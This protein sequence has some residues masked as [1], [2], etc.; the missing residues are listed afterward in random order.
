MLA[1]LVMGGVLPEQWDA[2][3]R[4]VDFFD[5]K[6]DLEALLA[7][8]GLEEGFRFVAD[9]HSALH[10]GQCARIQRDGASVGWLGM[11]H[12]ELEGRLELPA[13]TY[14]FELRL[15]GIA[16]GILPVFRPLSKFPSIR[17]DLA[18]VV[19]E[20]VSFGQ[21]RDCIRSGA[22]EILQDILLFDVYTGDKIDSGR[23]SLAL[24]LILQD[25]SHTLTDEEVETAVGGIL[26]KLTD[27]TGANLR[28]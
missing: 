27:E 11:L 25:S 13:G 6:A 14:L 1:G 24:G 17:R 18:L 28:D 15:S 2:E 8:L 4:S 22:P 10:P 7:Q 9:E 5:V 23:K 26:Q 21:I 3:A 12:P 20:Q 19:N 16:E